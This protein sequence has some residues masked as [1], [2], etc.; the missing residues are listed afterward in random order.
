FV[1][2]VLSF[3]QVGDPETSISARAKHFQPDTLDRYILVRRYAPRFLDAG[4]ST[5]LRRD[6]K[7]IYYGLLAGAAL[8]FRGPAFWQYHRRGLK[9]LG[10]V[11]D[12]SYLSLLAG[13]ELLWMLG[14]PVS[15]TTRAVRFSKA[16]IRRN[17]IRTPAHPPR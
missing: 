6:A 8:R 7:R 14:N 9:T 1:H 11:I 2:Q 12:W 4:E 3:L 17:L 15:T 13:K 10:E 5:A 16:T